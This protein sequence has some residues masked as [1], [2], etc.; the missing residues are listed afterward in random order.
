MPVRCAHWISQRDQGLFDMQ[1]VLGLSTSH[2]VNALAAEVNDDL[3]KVMAGLRS[4]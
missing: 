1:N 3:Q 2:E 4:D